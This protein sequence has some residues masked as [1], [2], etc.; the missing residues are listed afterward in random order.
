MN[1]LRYQC[2]N[3]HD[4]FGWSSIRSDKLPEYCHVCAKLTQP[5]QIYEYE[6][7]EP[8]GLADLL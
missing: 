7:P 8:P 6:P 4:P 2:F 1:Y 5:Y 3:G